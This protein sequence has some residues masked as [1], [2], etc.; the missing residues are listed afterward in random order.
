MKEKTVYMK[1]MKTP[2]N[3]YRKQCEKQN[4]AAH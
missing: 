4:V 1:N 2:Y 3:P